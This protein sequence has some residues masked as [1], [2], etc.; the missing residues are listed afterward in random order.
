MK[1][2]LFLV[3]AVGILFLTAINASALV[4]QKT[5][6]Y[7]TLAVVV[8]SGAPGE[9][10]VDE[11]KMVRF[12][13]QNPV[14]FQ[15]NTS[16]NNGLTKWKIEEGGIVSNIYMYEPFQWIDKIDE[17]YII[18]AE[19]VAEG[20]LVRLKAAPDDPD[21][22]DEPDGPDDPEPNPD[23]P[24]EPNPLPP[25]KEETPPAIPVEQSGWIAE[26]N[27]GGMLKGSRPLNP[28]GV[29]LGSRGRPAPRPVTSAEIRQTAIAAALELR[30]EGG[31]DGGKVR[32]PVRNADIISP[33][34]AN[35]ITGAVNKV[36][37]GVPVETVVEADT[38]RDGEVTARMYI[39]INDLQN[40]DKAVRLRVDNDAKSRVNRAVQM[41]FQRHFNNRVVT[42]AFEQQGPFGMDISVAIKT[43]L[44]GL[45]RDTLFF[46]A[47][48]TEHNA[49][50][51]MDTAYAVDSR[52]YLHFV[53][54]YGGSVVITDRP[55]SLKNPRPL[56]AAETA[57][58]SPGA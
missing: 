49:Y 8:D 43:D 2:M 31:A 39:D 40:N 46:Y 29:L 42:A 26:G 16:G 3:M 7:F 48:E 53:T 56:S 34:T 6:G 50:R 27:G 19:D 23:T 38:V 58:G 24:P 41:R 15:P 55:L 5:P 30:E 9:Y 1:K 45:N 35:N 37:D 51:R 11:T 17:P 36:L 13:Y 52:G 25:V 20:K 32:I 33:E 44:S 14:D 47:Y 57:R 28:G 10:A 21:E 22:P 54:G 18:T 12:I 4:P